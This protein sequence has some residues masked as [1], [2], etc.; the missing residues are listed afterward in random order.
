MPRK[1]PLFPTFTTLLNRRPTLPA[2]SAIA[3]NGLRFGSRGTDY[4]PS[5]RKRKRTFG[6]LARIRS[7]TGR[8]IIS[9][10]L[11]KG[12]KNMSH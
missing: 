5:T 2:I 4:Q 12:K 8:K 3:A 10:R 11:K 6:F 7:R 9:R 1:I